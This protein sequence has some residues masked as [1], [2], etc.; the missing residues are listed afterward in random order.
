MHSPWG[1]GYR[2]MLVDGWKGESRGF[3][4]DAV[5]VRIRLGWGCGDIGKP[6]LSEQEPG[7]EAIF[8]MHLCSLTQK[9]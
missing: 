4:G 2:D 9:Q 8:Q 3:H 5:K 6:F 1:Q 7:A